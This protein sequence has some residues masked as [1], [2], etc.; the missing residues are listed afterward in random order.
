MQVT[1]K[2]VI[3]FEATRL[4]G[5]GTPSAPASKRAAAA[6]VYEMT[7]AGRGATTKFV[8]DPGAANQTA[9]CIAAEPQQRGVEHARSRSNVRLHASRRRDQESR[10]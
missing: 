7:V 2:E 4:G 1:E 9:R 5:A 6:F 10:R 3:S 8:I